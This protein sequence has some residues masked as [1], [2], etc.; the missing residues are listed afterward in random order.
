MFWLKQ[1]T[2]FGCYF[3]GFATKR[4]FNDSIKHVVELSADPTTVNVFHCGQRENGIDGPA[5]YC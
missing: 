1:P 2:H 3:K 4:Q 5:T